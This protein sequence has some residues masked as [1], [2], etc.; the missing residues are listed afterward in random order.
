[1]NILLDLWAFK[2]IRYFLM[3]FGILLIIVIIFFAWLNVH[4]TKLTTTINNEWTVKIANAKPEIKIEYKE[5]KI[6]A[7]KPTTQKKTPKVILESEHQR[8]LDSAKTVWL[9]INA[10]RDSLIEHYTE[11]TSAIFEDSVESCVVTVNP[12]ATIDNIMLQ[13]FPKE[14]TVKLPYTTETQKILIPEVIPWYRSS[15]AYYIYGILSAGII[16]AG[17]N[18]V[19]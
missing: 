11:I 5:T 1:M 7:A 17:T 8:L 10:D 16:Y 3:S 15:T 14:Q 6:P 12:M 18:A 2:P 13:K 19:K 9:S 4:D